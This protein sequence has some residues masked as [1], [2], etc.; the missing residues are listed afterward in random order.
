MWAGTVNTC[1]W[2]PDEKGGL[3]CRCDVIL[4]VGSVSAHVLEVKGGSFSLRVL[5]A[6]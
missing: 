3:L 6:T 1:G 4:G 5:K 2:W